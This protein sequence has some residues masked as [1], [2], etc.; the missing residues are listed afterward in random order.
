MHGAARRLQEAAVVVA[1][2][3]LL[4]SNAVD[5][6]ELERP[7]VGLDARMSTSAPCLLPQGRGIR[8]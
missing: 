4:P 8:S 5:D 7:E 2:E 3:G 6:D 1:S